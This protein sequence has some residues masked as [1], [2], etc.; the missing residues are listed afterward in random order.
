MIRRL[1]STVAGATARRL[2]SRRG[3]DRQARIEFLATK[4]WSTPEQPEPATP[5]VT[6]PT[7]T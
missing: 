4:L 3:R 7:T 5:P 2:T 6:P 1:T